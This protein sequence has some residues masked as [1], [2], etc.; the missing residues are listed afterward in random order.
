MRIVFLIQDDPLYILPFFQKL[1]ARSA[2]HVD[3]RA[4]FACRS[5]GSRK[6]S[7]LLV[8][9]FR[10]YGV[11]GFAKLISLQLWT[12]LA[13]LVGIGAFNGTAYSLRSLARR[14]QIPY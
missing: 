9:L 6:R 13:D 2:A 12:R 11:F 14:K 3:Y 4:I 5:M 8:E 7:K 1:F 10:L